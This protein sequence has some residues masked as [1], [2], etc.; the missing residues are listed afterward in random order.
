[1]ARPQATRWQPVHGILAAFPLALFVATLVSDIA[2][3][4]SA[5]IQ[6]ANFSVWLIAGGVMM[7]V[8][9]ALFG[10][11]DAVA[12]RRQRRRSE[13]VRDRTQSPDRVHRILTIVT[14]VFAIINGFIHSRDGWTAVVPTGLILSAIT[15][16]LIVVVSWLGYAALGRHEGEVR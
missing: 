4:R 6:W 12:H 15:A 2:Y 16:V 1:M 11:V 13:H 14:L 10:I 5:N 3:A 9:A 7:G 8:L